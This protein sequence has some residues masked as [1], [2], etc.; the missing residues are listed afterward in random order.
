ME[1]EG[2]R[3]ASAC[4]KTCIGRTWLS[5]LTEAPCRSLAVGG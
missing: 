3:E 1:V 2:E 4:L 5:M